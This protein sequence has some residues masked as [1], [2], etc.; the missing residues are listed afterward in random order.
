[1][2]T[3][4]AAWIITLAGLLSVSSTAMAQFW[5]GRGYYDDAGIWGAYTSAINNATSRYVAQSDRLAGERAANQQMLA[6]QRGIQNTLSSQ[7]TMRTQNALSQ[8]QNNRDMWF[9]V[10]QQQ[11]AQRRSMGPTAYASPSIPVGLES[12]PTTPAPQ[13]ATDIIA[14]PAVLCDPRFAQQRAAIEAPY[15]G[16][17]GLSASPTKAQYQTMIDTATDMKATLGHMTN[18]ISAREYLD[19]EKFLDQLSTEAEQRIKEMAPAK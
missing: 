10:Q 14:W 11:V 9:Q 16:K 6:M 12:V 18:E 7:A 13:V 17:S 19:T 1:M 2:R 8:Q 5:P 15:R 3:P 4:H